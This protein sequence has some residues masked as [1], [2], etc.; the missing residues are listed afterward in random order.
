MAD[1][2]HQDLKYGIIY[3][4]SDPR[5]SSGFH[6]PESIVKKFVYPMQ[7]EWIDDPGRDDLLLIARR[8]N[9]GNMGRYATVSL[10]LSRMNRSGG[11]FEAIRHFADA[12]MGVADA[13]DGDIVINESDYGYRYFDQSSV[14]GEAP[15]ATPQDHTRVENRSKPSFWKRMKEKVDEKLQDISLDEAIGGTVK[16]NVSCT[17]EETPTDYTSKPDLLQLEEDREV[18]QL[19]Q[20]RK[21]ALEQIKHQIVSY[22]ARYHEDPK[23][24]ISELI[25]FGS[26]VEVLAPDSL[27]DQIKQ[28]IAQMHEIY[29]GVKNDFTTGS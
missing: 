5:Y 18:K 15:C 28:K 7:I 4:Y 17:R 6:E 24:L 3:L 8:F 26:D 23:E 14:F 20:E 21:K 13:G 16:P 27:R 2:N 10:S 25:W 11:W 19:E 12:L 9:V 1:L 22:I 29:F